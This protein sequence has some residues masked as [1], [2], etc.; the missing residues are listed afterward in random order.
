MAFRLRLPNVN[1]T[2]VDECCNRRGEPGRIVRS[3]IKNWKDTGA[4]AEVSKVYL[5]K[6]HWA[7]FHRMGLTRCKEKGCENQPREDGSQRCNI[8][9]S[10]RSG[11]VSEEV[12]VEVE[13]ARKYKTLGELQKDIKKNGKDGGIFFGYLI[14]TRFMSITHVK[15]HLH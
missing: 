15:I 3:E 13:W 4:T 9:P 5:C 6:V 11:Q 8:H 7:A 2:L 10:K 14:A 12:R 1:A